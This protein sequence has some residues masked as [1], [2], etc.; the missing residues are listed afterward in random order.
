[1][2]KRNLYTPV[3]A[4][5]LGVSAVGLTTMLAQLP[6][7]DG[8]VKAR[9]SGGPQEGIR[10]HGHWTIEI[11]N[12]DGTVVTRR[13]FENALIGGPTLANIL[14]RVSSVSHW[15]VQIS[16][17]SGSPFPCGSTVCF[18][19]EAGSGF[20]PAGGAVF[21]NLTLTRSTSKLTLSGNA[22][23]SA[24]SEVSLVRTNLLTCDAKV[25][26]ASPCTNAVSLGS[27]ITQKDL[28]PVIPV[29]TGQQI[30]VTVEIS[31]S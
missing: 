21:K 15:A 20:S 13:E 19:T 12:P 30:Q 10:V 8:S 31:F 23:A 18:I 7:R 1:M 6:H 29:S 11:R 4:F 14:A 2:N 25:A 22:T 24:N 17:V 27:L 9:P 26:P 3:L 16:R 28:N 5:L